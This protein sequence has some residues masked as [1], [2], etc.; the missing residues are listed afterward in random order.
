M[1]VEEPPQTTTSVYPTSELLDLREP[2][3]RRKH[4]TCFGLP[5]NSSL[6]C[7]LMK[8]TKTE[9]P[10]SQTIASAGNYAKRHTTY[11]EFAVF[12]STNTLTIS[13]ISIPPS[14]ASSC[15]RC[16]PSQ[17]P[18]PRILKSPTKPPLLSLGASRQ[19][20]HSQTANLP[21]GGCV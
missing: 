19:S 15:N 18:P 4:P 17:S 10:L 9:S 21:R 3:K 12:Y 7:L 8:G 20:A 11:K 6:C 14:P 1:G 2:P 5:C 13:S 16:T